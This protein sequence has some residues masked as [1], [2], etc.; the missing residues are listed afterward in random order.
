MTFLPRLNGKTVPPVAD[1]FWAG[2]SISCAENKP[3]PSMFK[4]EQ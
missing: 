3:L 4:V 2:G 1:K